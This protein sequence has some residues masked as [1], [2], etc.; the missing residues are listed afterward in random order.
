MLS[1]S[2]GVIDK[3]GSFAVELHASL[4]E[5]VFCKRSWT[6]GVSVLNSAEAIE[7]SMF[8]SLFRSF[9]V[10]IRSSE[11]FLSLRSLSI[12]FKTFRVSS[13]EFLAKYTQS[14]YMS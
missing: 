13:N 5:P 8:E 3:L 9:K 10:F 14:T 1:P 11:T 6:V 7:S 4:S 2:D 12:R